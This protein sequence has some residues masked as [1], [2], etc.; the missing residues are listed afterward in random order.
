MGLFGVS[1]AICDFDLNT[2]AIHN[3]RSTI[4][5]TNIVNPSGTT[6]RISFSLYD[7]G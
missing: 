4:G 2:D 3:N 1:T 7:K 5:L 6:R